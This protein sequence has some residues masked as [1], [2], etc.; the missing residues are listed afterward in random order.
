MALKIRLD[1]VVT[2]RIDTLGTRDLAVVAE[3]ISNVAGD[4]GAVGH[5]SFHSRAKRGAWQHV[6]P[7]SFL[8]LYRWSVD[9]SQPQDAVTIEDLIDRF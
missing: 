4:P 5:P 9:P 2:A 3:N 1:P 8:V 7:R 6:C